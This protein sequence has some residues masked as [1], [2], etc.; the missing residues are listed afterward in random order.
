[1]VA[2]KELMIISGRRLGGTVTTLSQ[3]TG[4]SVAAISRRHDAGIRKMQDDKILRAATD[5]VIDTYP[6]RNG[7]ES[8]ESEAYPPDFRKPRYIFSR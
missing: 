7:K 1:M 6:S 8:S 2:A 5:Q 3:L 4:L